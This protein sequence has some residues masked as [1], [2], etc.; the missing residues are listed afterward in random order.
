MNVMLKENNGTSNSCCLCLIS[1]F[2]HFC[3]HIT[4]SNA[5]AYF[6][7]IWVVLLQTLFMTC[8]LYF[9]IYDK[10]RHQRF[11]DTQADKNASW[12]KWY[13]WHHPTGTHDDV[14]KWKHFPRYWPF[15]KGIHQS[16]VDSLTM[17][18]Y[19]ELSSFLWSAPEKKRLSKQA[20]RRWFETL[21]HSLWC[22]CNKVHQINQDTDFPHIDLNKVSIR[23]G[24]DRTNGK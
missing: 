12:N 9:R 24:K 18:N 19:A 21:S 7:E 10:H 13:L 17:P 3:L 1:W 22:H 2:R 8:H 23:K 14:I 15:L 4:A 20:R 11:T 6:C 5:M 16:T